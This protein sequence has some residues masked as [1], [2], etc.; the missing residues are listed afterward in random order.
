VSEPFKKTFQHLDEAF[1]EMDRA[2]AEAS[3]TLGS[4][5]PAVNQSNPEGMHIVRFEAR[6][7]MDR[8]RL[9]RRFFSMACGVVFTGVTSIKFRDR[10]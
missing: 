4:V 1:E 7:G 6:G 8:L 10:K 9:A 5:D 3:K 2:F